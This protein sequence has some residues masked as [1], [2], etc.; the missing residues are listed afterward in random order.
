VSGGRRRSSP[1]VSRTYSDEP[2]YCTQ[3]IQLLLKASANKGDSQDGAVPDAAKENTEDEI[4]H[5]LPD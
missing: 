1:I 5:P 2:D 4:L 3:A